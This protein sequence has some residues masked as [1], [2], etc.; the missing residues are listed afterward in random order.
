MRR[1]DLVWAVATGVAA[2]LCLL[3]APLAVMLWAL[4]RIRPTR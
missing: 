2:L 3:C 4:D 1:D